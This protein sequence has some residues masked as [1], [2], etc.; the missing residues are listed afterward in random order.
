MAK[1]Q[2]AKTTLDTVNTFAE[3]LFP[4]IGAALMLLRKIRE[5]AKA[6]RDTEGVKTADEIEAQLLSQIALMRSGGEKLEA[7]ADEWFDKHPEFDPKTGARR[8]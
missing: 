1:S 8:P 7:V 2:T 4:T 3:K 6:R 5:A